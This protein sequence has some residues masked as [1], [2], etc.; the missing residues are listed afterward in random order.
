MILA[1]STTTLVVTSTES[2]YGAGSPVVLNP[3]PSLS[4]YAL[5]TS[6]LARPALVLEDFKSRRLHEEI[7][8]FY[9]KSLFVN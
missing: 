3:L 5:P 8:I 7:R 6:P 1:S 2:N 4:Q 9:E